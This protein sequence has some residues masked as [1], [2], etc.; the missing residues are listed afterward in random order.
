MYNTNVILFFNYPN[1]NRSIITY[2]EIFDLSASDYIEVYGKINN[3]DGNRVVS[4]TGST[5]KS[6]TFGAFK[7]I[8]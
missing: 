2:H 8:E 7:I 3:S 6:T 5:Q 1:T 4:G